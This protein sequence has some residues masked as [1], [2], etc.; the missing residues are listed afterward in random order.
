[1]SLLNTV[2][3]RSL[4]VSQHA[5]DSISK[6]ITSPESFGATLLIAAVDVLGPEMYSW[7][8][9]TI[10]LELQ[11]ELGAKIPPA[12][13]SRLF[14]AINILTTDD[15]SFRVSRFINLSN[16]L[17][18]DDF[19]PEEFDPADA[20]E[21][22]WAVT[23]SS[24]INPDH[25]DRFSEEIKG[26]VCFK[27]KE[28]GLARLP[29]VLSFAQPYWVSNNYSAEHFNTDPTMFAAVQDS[30]GQP[31]KEVEQAVQEACVRLFDQLQSLKLRNGDTKDLLQRLRRS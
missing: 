19:D 31:L 27:C 3:G 2:S 17:A 1:M 28:E 5:D 30:I 12:N 21:M 29:G 11:D 23:E 20:D 24:F 10:R 15:F 9:E 26:Y 18:G 6:A 22:A 25:L 4:L 16:I 8:P 13:L 14:A 7:T